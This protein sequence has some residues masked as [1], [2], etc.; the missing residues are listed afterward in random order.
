MNIG[1]RISEARI[2]KGWS[3]RELARRLN[4]DNAFISRIERGKL[5]P[6]LELLDSISTLLDVEF[7]YTDEEI[8]L[9]N[10]L[11]LSDDELIDKYNL[12][13]DG[14]EVSAKEI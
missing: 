6:N 11:E 10:D 14:K 13:V 8:N 9:M 4:K 2:K 3:Q 1:K 7:F 5:D 12:T